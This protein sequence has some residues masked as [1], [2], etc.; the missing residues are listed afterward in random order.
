MIRRRFLKAASA[1][2]LGL[3]S[4]ACQAVGVRLP[5]PPPVVPAAS[6]IPKAPATGLRALA[7]AMPW[8]DDL[9]PKPAYEAL[10][11]TRSVLNYYGERITRKVI[12]RNPQ[13]KPMAQRNTYENAFLVVT[14]PFTAV[15]NA[16]NSTAKN[17]V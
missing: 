5:A 9:Q 17:Y 1:I 6:P 16:V 11:R 4:T 2:P 7:D 13:A 8:D 15:S 10:R 12:E 3:A 14:Y